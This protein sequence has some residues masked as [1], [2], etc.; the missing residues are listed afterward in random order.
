MEG[1]RKK[2]MFR[3]S[4][5][6]FRE[7]DLV[8]GGFAKRWLPDFDEAALDEFEALLACEDRLLYAWVTGN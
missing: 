2:L 1:R 8:L 5:R 6:G 7:A 3:A 4:H